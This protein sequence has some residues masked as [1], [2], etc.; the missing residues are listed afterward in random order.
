MTTVPLPDDHLACYGCG[1]AVP[2][3]ADPS[4][5]VVADVLPRGIA[6]GVAPPPHA[7]ARQ[8]SFAR[9]GSC[10]AARTHAEQMVAERPRL[11]QR[12]GPDSA[13]HRVEC[14][15]LA[16]AAVGAR[17]GD[18]DPSDLVEWLAAPG[19]AARWLARLSP[20]V[21]EGAALATCA[22]HPW[23]HL[24]D[25]Q[26]TACLTARGRALR[27]RLA[28]S[29][30]PV[31]VASPS[32]GG[33][34]MCGVAAVSVPAVDVE[35][36]GGPLSTAQRVWRPVTTTVAALGGRPSPALLA[37]H[38]CPA[39]ADATDAVGAVGPTAMERAVRA[40]L[41]LGL[42]LD[43]APLDGLKGWVA[44]GGREPNPEPWDHCDLS[45]LS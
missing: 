45:A 22:P 29:A 27:A 8:V 24:T 16:L 6:P 2:T 10:A 35:R 19:A 1:V 31:A 20:F 17:V 43:A 7:R 40:H 38:L 26:R 42:G 39:C 44:L 15:L 11:A 23:A 9:C 28:R 33:C 37:G 5:V 30:P 3:P 4:L 36:D 21:S 32:H 25:E 18:E 13:V 14:G 34:L 12:L 41:G